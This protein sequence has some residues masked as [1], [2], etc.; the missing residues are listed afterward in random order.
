MST[1]RRRDKTC[2]ETQGTDQAVS[3]MQHSNTL[4]RET[5]EMAQAAGHALDRM[6]CSFTHIN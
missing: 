3:A 5:L 1:K 6:A 4:A 2:L